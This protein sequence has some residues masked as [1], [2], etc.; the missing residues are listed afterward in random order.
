M[1]Q[2]TGLSGYSQLLS[3]IL[4]QD[5]VMQK[6]MNQIIE[7]TRSIRSQVEFT[8]DYQNMGVKSPRWQNVESMAKSAAKSLALKGLDIQIKT[9]SLEIFADTDAGKGICQHP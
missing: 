2:I 8:R 1:N 9:G 6:Y 4:P 7:L 5:T 3:E